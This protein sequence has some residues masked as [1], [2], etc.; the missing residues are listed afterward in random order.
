M[1]S[2]APSS[3]AVSAVSRSRILLIGRSP[4]SLRRE[5]HGGGGGARGRAWMDFRSKSV[6]RREAGSAPC[7]LRLLAMLALRMRRFSQCHLKIFLILSLR[8]QAHVEGRRM[9]LQRPALRCKLSIG[10][11]AP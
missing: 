6:I 3:I 5:K 4:K 8:R 11:T 1:A 7:V 2:L 10:M 9:V